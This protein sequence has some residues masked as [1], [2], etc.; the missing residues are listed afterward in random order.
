MVSSYF[1]PGGT[2][3]LPQ[4]VW[5]TLIPVLGGALLAAILAARRPQVTDDDDTEDFTKALQSLGG[6]GL[7]G[8]AIAAR[9]EAL[10]KPPSLAGAGR[11][12][13]PCVQEQQ[14]AATGPGERND[15]VFDHLGKRQISGAPPI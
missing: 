10:S 2:K 14:L 4:W 1:Y 9:D 7:R 13:N 11:V 12:S 3:P 8:A 5:F 15:S 6:R